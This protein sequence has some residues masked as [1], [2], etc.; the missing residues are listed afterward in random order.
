MIAPLLLCVGIVTADQGS[1]SN[2]PAS[3]VPTES[4][5]PTSPAGP[6]P[7]EQISTAPGESS[8]TPAAVPLSP[9]TPS[10][11]LDRKAARQSSADQSTGTVAQRRLPWWLTTLFGLAVV[12]VLLFICSRA[13]RWA[14]PGND[15]WHDQGP[16]HVL[17]RVPVG[18]KHA[19]ALIRCGE[20]LLLVGVGGESMQTL[21]EITSREEIDYLKGLCLQA[22]PR[23]ASRAFAELLSGQRK[24]F[25]NVEPTS[26]TESAEDRTSRHPELARQLDAAR[27]RIRIWKTG[28]NS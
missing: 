16:I 22:R 3:A 27:E 19:L 21:A 25:S 5:V 26:P 7:V 2:Q 12:L 24:S 18:P 15:R 6:H 1:T 28:A 8:S 9:R 10:R 13:M 4:A 11:L 23:S 17:Y 20:R 14:M